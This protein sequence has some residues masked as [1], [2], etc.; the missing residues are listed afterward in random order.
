[1][2][3]H[4]ARAEW[5]GDFKSGKGTIKPGSATFSANFSMDS[6]LGN[7]AGTNPTEILVAALAGC[8]SSTLAHLLAVSGFEPKQIIAET[9][10]HLQKV[11]ESYA[12]TRIDL[13]AVA[14]VPN[15]DDK[16]L[17]ELAQKAE[18]LC[19]VGKALSAV[20]ISLRAKLI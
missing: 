1:M 11:G 2:A 12:I 8:F 18:K 16:T 5:T 4:T 20:E 10:G 19:P 13:N 17:Q 15:L 9:N 14:D 3:S 7:G 6:V